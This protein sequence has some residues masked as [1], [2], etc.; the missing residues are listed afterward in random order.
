[1]STRNDVKRYKLRP[2][3]KPDVAVISQ[4]FESLEDLSL[5][6]RSMRVPVDKDS[7][8]KSWLEQT[9]NNG[10][11]SKCWFAI[12]NKPD[13]ICGIVGLEAISSINGDAVLAIFIAENHRKKGIAIRAA[14]L[15]L[16]LAFN[17]LRL[18][19]V[20]SF[21]RT[22]N[23]ASRQLTQQVGFRKEGCHRKAWFTGGKY[24]DMISVG[25][26]SSEWS[27]H[28]Q[29]L[30]AQ[31]SVDTTVQFGRGGHGDWSWPPPVKVN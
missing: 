10:G 27:R 26:L 13:D 6:D 22:D 18:N 3:H 25:L 19:R 17:Q 23:Q 14:A 30:A 24:L 9:T 11:N 31:L 28:R 12:E 7:A 2:L 8:E 29:T 20:S 21:Y 4:W 1:M 16:D 5:F 15:A